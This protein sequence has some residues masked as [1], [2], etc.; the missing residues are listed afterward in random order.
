MRALHGHGSVA[1]SS[2]LKNIA[3]PAPAALVG[4]L[5]EEVRHEA[6][7]VVAV[8]VVHVALILMC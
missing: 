8:E 2:A 6:V 1:A 5:V 3:P 7:A 4:K